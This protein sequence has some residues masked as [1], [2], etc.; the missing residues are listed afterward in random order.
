MAYRGVIFTWSEKE[1]CTPEKDSVCAIYMHKQINN[2]QVSN[3]KWPGGIDESPCLTEGKQS[4]RG[5]K[6][7]THLGNYIDIYLWGI[8][9]SVTEF[10]ADCKEW[11][12]KHHHLI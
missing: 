3:E 7:E 5:W 6:C 1:R 2:T 11:S 4:G 8:V 12:M 10:A 9:H